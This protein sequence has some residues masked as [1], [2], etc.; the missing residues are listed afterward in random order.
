[1]C[2]INYA[3]YNNIMTILLQDSKANNSLD[4]VIT[5]SKHILTLF[6]LRIDQYISMAVHNSITA[7]IGI[8][9][10]YSDWSVSRVGQQQLYHFEC[11]STR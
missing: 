4:L 5:N 3:C 1:M 11:V 9:T 6:Q 10:F 2:I 7:I 8:S